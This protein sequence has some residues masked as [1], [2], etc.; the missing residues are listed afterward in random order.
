MQRLLRGDMQHSQEADIRAWRG[1]Q[2]AFPASK[3]LHTHNINK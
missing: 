1:F 2:V 3:Q